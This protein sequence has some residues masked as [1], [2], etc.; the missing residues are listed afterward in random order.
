MTLGPGCQIKRGGKKSLLKTS[1]LRVA[2]LSIGG[3]KWKARWRDSH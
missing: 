1:L 3:E 2:L